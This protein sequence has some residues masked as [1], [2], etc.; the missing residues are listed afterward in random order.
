MSTRVASLSY[1]SASIEPIEAELG[2]ALSGD[3]RLRSKLAFLF[4]IG[5]IRTGV[6]LLAQISEDFLGQISGASLRTSSQMQTI[7]T[8][9]ENN[10]IKKVEMISVY[11]FF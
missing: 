7:S 5:P 6:F 8:M 9:K 11:F 10:L 3:S 1:G 2:S 4:W